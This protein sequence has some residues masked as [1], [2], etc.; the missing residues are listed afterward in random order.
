MSKYTLSSNHVK[1]FVAHKIVK[2]W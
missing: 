2:T 1:N